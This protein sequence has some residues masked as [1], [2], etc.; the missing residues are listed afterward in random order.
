MYVEALNGLRSGASQ[1]LLLKYDEKVA[2]QVQVQGCQVLFDGGKVCRAKLHEAPFPRKPRGGIQLSEAACMR[3]SYCCAD[4][5]CRK[6]TTPPSLRFLGPK[7]YL[8]VV[9]VIVAALRCGETPERLSRLQELVGVSRQTVK[10]WLQWW[11]EV[12]PAATDFWR[13]RSGDLRTKVEFCELPQSLLD[14]FSGS[15]K[16]QVLS[17]LRFIAVMTGGKRPGVP[18]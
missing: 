18:L 15:I 7:L 5:D 1:E 16:D 6:R 10:R 2:K 13:A 14:E 12:L 8:A 4:R 9:V 11:R 3:L 17:L